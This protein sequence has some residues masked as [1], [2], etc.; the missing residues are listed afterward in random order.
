MNKIIL[1]LLLLVA[2][3]FPQKKRHVITKRYNNIQLMCKTIGLT[4]FKLNDEEEQ[5]YQETFLTYL[6]IKILEDPK[7]FDLRELPLPKEELAE[8]RELKISRKYKIFANL[9]KFLNM[10]IDG[11]S[12][13]VIIFI[14]YFYHYTAEIPYGSDPYSYTPS[15][16][17]Y[18]PGFTIIEKE[19]YSVG[20]V[21]WDNRAGR[22]IA[23]GFADTGINLDFMANTVYKT[24]TFIK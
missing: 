7:G 5:N 19:K 13:D 15:G 11:F 4:A 24:M 20:Y 12:P 6:K 10:E 2:A 16:P 22:V 8:T 9:P 14:P 18:G 23:Y 3:V 21:F 1:I 17:R